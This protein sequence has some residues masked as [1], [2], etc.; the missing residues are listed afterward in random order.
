MEIVNSRHLPEEWRDTFI[1][2]DFRGNRV[3]AF[4]LEGRWQRL[5]IDEAE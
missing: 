4:P 5:S 1:T 2:N 3:N